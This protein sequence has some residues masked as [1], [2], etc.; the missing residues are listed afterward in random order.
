MT[1]HATTIAEL[2]H[3]ISLCDDE[4]ETAQANGWPDQAA[5]YQAERTDIQAAIADGT[6]AGH[7]LA[8]VRIEDSAEADCSSPAE[9]RHLHAD[10]IRGGH[11]E[12]FSP[13][14]YYSRRPRTMRVDGGRW[15]IG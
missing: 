6:L 15:I 2:E 13:D 8:A 1:L 10:L 4:I 7:G 14:A 9:R 3:Y 5:E 11:G 12:A